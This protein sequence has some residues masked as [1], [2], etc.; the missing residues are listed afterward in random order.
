MDWYENESVHFF[1]LSIYDS[2]SAAEG[3][4]TDCQPSSLIDLKN[5][6][7]LKIMVTIGALFQ[8]SQGTF[9]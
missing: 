8:L 4:N 5:F 6:K 9:G 7:R 3:Q 1:N 2:K